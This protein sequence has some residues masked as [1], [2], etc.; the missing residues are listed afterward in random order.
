MP[1]VKIPTDDD[2]LGN[3]SVEGGVIFPFAIDLPAEWGMGLMT[4]IDVNR[5]SSGGDYHP[6]FINSI[7]FS[8]PIFGKLGGYME[9]FSLVSS[10]SGMDWIGTADFGLVYALSENIQLDAGVNFGITRAADDYNPFV[11]ITF[12]F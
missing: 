9:F 11:G 6:E 5:D 12:R 2:G 4:E 7:T 3:G 1:F 8:H 10:E